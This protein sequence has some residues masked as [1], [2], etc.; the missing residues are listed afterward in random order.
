M[1]WIMLLAYAEWKG[2]APLWQKEVI[3][4]TLILE[5]RLRERGE[6][7]GKPLLSRVLQEVW[8]FFESLPPEE[9]KDAGRD[10]VLDE[11]KEVVS[12]SMDNIAEGTRGAIWEALRKPFSPRENIFREVVGLAPLEGDKDG[13]QKAAGSYWSDRSA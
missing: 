4:E 9:T 3:C 8:T 1:N 11:F 12:S 10:Q 7:V 5:N 13:D 6:L 2:N